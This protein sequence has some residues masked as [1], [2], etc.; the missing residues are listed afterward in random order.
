MLSKERHTP[1]WNT[2][3]IRRLNIMGKDQFFI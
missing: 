2:F 3:L 1:F